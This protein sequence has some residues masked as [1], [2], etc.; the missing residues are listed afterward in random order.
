MTLPP[1]LRLTIFAPSQFPVRGHPAGAAG[2]ASILG[3]SFT[4]TEL[5]VTMARPALELSVV[6][7]EGIAGQV[8]EE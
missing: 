2:R 4:V 7:A 8:L 5:S 3:S 6:L 1:T